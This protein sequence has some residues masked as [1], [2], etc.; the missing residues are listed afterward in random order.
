MTIVFTV[1]FFIIG[2]LITSFT[3]V[4]GLRI[5]VGESIVRP[6]SHCPNCGHLLGALELTPVIGYLAL[7]GKCRDTTDEETF[8][9]IQTGR[10]TND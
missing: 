4:V 1:Y 7:R 9:G 6:R 10:T 8:D 2:M 5:P 3:N